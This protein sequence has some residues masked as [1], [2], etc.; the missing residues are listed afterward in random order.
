MSPYSISSNNNNPL[1]LLPLL[2][3]YLRSSHGGCIPC[4]ESVLSRRRARPPVPPPPT[5]E[6]S[7]F[8]YALSSRI[9]ELTVDNGTEKLR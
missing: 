3:P 6:S 4:H 9:K 2:S 5:I 7:I 8:T 1:L